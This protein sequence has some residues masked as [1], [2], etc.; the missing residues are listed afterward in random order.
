MEG[1]FRLIA[2]DVYEVLAVELVEGFLRSRRRGARRSRGA[3]RVRAAPGRWACRSSR[4]RSTAPAIST[5]LLEV[6]LQTLDEVCGFAHSMMLV[7]DE[8]RAAPGDHRQPRLRRAGRAGDRRRGRRRRG[9]HRHGGRAS[10]KVLRV[11]S[12]EGELR[13][14]RAIRQRAESAGSGASL[15]PEIPL[16]GLPDAQSQLALPLVVQDRLVG[17]LALE[18]RDP[19]AFGTWD[20]ALLQ[21]LANQIAI[22][23]DRNASRRRRRRRGRRRPR[24]RRSRRP[25]RRRPPAGRAARSPSSATTTACSSTA[26]T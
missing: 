26:S 25:R 13:Y 9:L 22:G 7:P 20:E 12:V 5:Q 18:S 1:I 19:L 10:S 11:S 17:V 6:L 2:A 4:S 24:R 8:S 14:G 15:R 16:P 21:I 23:I 3:A